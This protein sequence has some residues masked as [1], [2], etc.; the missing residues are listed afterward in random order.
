[1]IFVAMSAVGIAFISQSFLREVLFPESRYF[2]ATNSEKLPKRFQVYVPV[3]ASDIRL[4]TYQSAWWITVESTCTEADAA[5]WALSI[6]R[7]LDSKGAIPD[8]PDHSLPAHELGFVPITNV[9]DRY[10]WHVGSQGNVSNIVYDRKTQRLYYL[11][12]RI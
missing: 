12:S 9:P 1:M 7:P 6:N 3:S 5:N 2:T 10:V 8:L 11:K 4:R